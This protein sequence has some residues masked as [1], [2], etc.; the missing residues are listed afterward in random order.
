MSA[1]GGDTGPPSA[2]SSQ[3]AERPR[4][5]GEMLER[6]RAFLE[7]K[8]VEEARLDADLL[9]AHA[10]EV[11]R[12]HLLL[13]LEEPVAEEELVRARSLLQRR[14]ATEP[15][16]YITGAREFYGR[17]FGV[18][19]G[20]L[21]PRPE[22]ELIVDLARDHLAD[23]EQAP[24]ILDIGT[25]SGC[26]AIT[27]ALEVSSATVHAVDVS[28]EA[29]EVA[30]A[31]ATS[32]DAEVTWLEQDGLQAAGDGAPWDLIVCNPPYV[33]P[34]ERESLAPE[35]RDHEPAGALFAP[36]D[37][38]HYWVRSLAQGARGWLRSGGLM[39]VEL[40]HE[41]G[42]AALELGRQA[43][44]EARVEQDLAGIPRVLVL[45]A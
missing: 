16:A 40:G 21:I 25:G 7:R 44:P 4:N 13:R 14:A 28:G 20:V 37:D 27:L 41:Q 31:N 11:D 10:L 39:L 23:R 35:V 30:R 32:L 6:A 42:P 36:E 2:S 12:L 43:D 9:V 22:T 5:V 1:Q 38:V 24:R 33:N 3:T 29:L 8:G 18:C 17:S 19:S 45:G 34:A 26:L 15:V